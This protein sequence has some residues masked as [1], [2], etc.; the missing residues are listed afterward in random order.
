M[1]FQRW[2]SWYPCSRAFARFK[3]HHTEI[4]ELY[5]SFVPAAENAKYLGRHAPADAETAALL[6]ATG[7]R[8]HRLQPLA[9]DWLASFREFENWTR[10]SG[11]LSALSYLE[12]FI[13]ATVTLSLRSDPLLRFGQAHAIDG[14][15][16]IKKSVADDV[17]D[18]VTGC[19][20]GEWSKR[21]AAYSR[22][23]GAAPPSLTAAV[24]D[25]EQMR[26]LRNGIAHGFG[27]DLRTL[28]DPLAVNH[29]VQERLSE[30]TLQRWLGVIEQ[31]A[32]GI[33]EH[34]LAAHLGDFELL[35]HFHRW[36]VL[37]R[38]KSELSYS[39]ARAFGRFLMRSF[40]MTPG[41][42]HCEQLEGYYDQ[43]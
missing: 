24:G 36:R 29:G 11:L 5:W 31:V 25:L 43:L 12:T 4:N 35:W 17:T 33:D 1:A 19:V 16:W 26:N 38:E 20:K 37:P 39:N 28:G 27:R 2:T 32:I 8:A 6:H 22:L 14:V 15:A 18:L 40:G 3:D 41:K 7:P 34:L 30:E 10:L 23:F 21:I 9:R 42:E 13:S